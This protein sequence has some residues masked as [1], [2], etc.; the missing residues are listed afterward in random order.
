MV[1]KHNGDLFAVNNRCTTRR[2]CTDIHTWVVAM[3]SAEHGVRMTECGRWLACVTRSIYAH[4]RAY[5]FVCPLQ[6]CSVTTL[7]LLSSRGFHVSFHLAAH[8]QDDQ[9][10]HHQ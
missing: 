9:S 4:V 6:M 5:S 8:T 1:V 7:R 10:A 2:K 3:M